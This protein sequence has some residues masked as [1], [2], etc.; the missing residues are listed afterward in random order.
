MPSGCNANS[1]A[2][3]SENMFHQKSK[4]NTRRKKKKNQLFQTV[5]K[6]YQSVAIILQEFI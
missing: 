3:I 4:E 5:V 1:K 2:G 6:I